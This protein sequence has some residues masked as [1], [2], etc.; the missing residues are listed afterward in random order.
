MFKIV[1]TIEE[2]N[3]KWAAKMYRIKF[4]LVTY[5]SLAV[6]TFIVFWAISINVVFPV[7][8]SVLITLGFTPVCVAT[9]YYWVKRTAPTPEHIVEWVEFKRFLLIVL[10]IIPFV[11]ILPLSTGVYISLNGYPQL[12]LV[13]GIG[14]LR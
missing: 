2:K 9:S 13:T 10:F 4:A 11:A 14:G 8:W 7:P 5:A 1:E 12:A 3:G 6:P